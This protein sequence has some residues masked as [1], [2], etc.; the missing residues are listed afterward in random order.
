MKQ[1]KTTI[2]AKAVE[3]LCKKEEMRE[4]TNK[5]DAG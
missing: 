1:R 5:A 2:E 3:R 4:Q